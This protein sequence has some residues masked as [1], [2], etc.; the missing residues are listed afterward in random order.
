MKSRDSLH[1]IGLSRGLALGLL[2]SLAA[3]GAYAGERIDDGEARQVRVRY[4]DLDLTSPEGM[5][6]L[7]GRLKGAARDACGGIIGVRDLRQILAYHECYDSALNEAVT[8]VGNPS[9]HA[10]HAAR[11]GKTRVG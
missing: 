11:S 8:E 6:T 1:V 9:L 10:L 2:G 4:S 5:Q 3:V 7:Y